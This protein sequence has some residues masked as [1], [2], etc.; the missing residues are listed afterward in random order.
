MNKGTESGFTIIELIVVIIILGI[1][2]ATALPR[3]MEATER[4]HDAS[5]L[6]AVGAFA[7]SVSLVKAQ[8][9]VNGNSNGDPENDVDHY[10]EGNIDVTGRGWAYA[11]S[12]VAGRHAE[13]GKATR[14]RAELELTNQECANL[15][16]AIMRGPTAA[17]F[18]GR[19][20]LSTEAEY[21]AAVIRG[22]STVDATATTVDGASKTPGPVIGCQ[23]GYTAST[24]NKITTHHGYRWLSYDFRTGAVTTNVKVT[25]EEGSA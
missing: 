19:L 15:W 10:G 11:V 14:D 7:S 2:A 16:M 25:Y 20:P 3:F 17:A 4:A 8:W 1:L 21:A 24:S 6:G 9:Y 23:Y 18:A 22:P 5:V 13:Y 12:A